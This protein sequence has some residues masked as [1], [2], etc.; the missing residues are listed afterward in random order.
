MK[1]ITQRRLAW[2]G[3][4]GVL[5]GIALIVVRAGSLGDAILDLQFRVP[6]DPVALLGN[7]LVIGSALF[8]V[9]LRSRWG[10]KS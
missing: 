9:L 3:F 4:G 1:K 6:Q 5:L 8:L 7:I 10:E 2:A